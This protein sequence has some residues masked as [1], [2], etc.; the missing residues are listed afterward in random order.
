MIRVTRYTLAL[1]CT[2]ILTLTALPPAVAALVGVAQG[3]SFGELQR[4]IDDIQRQLTLLRA[5]VDVT[6]LAAIQQDLRALERGERLARVEQE[7][8]LDRLLIGS[9]LTAL[10][11]NLAVA[12]LGYR[13]L[14][15]LTYGGGNK[16]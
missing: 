5:Q 3:P 13:R 10:V 11:G 6:N 8:F 1:L 15:L 14:Q 7:V 12:L 4:E 9:A 16:P 2:L